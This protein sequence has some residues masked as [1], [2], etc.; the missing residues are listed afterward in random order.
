MSF[1]NY[2]INNFSLNQ[3]LSYQDL[4]DLAVNDTILYNK[5]QAMPRGI[6]GFAEMRQ[7]HSTIN[8]FKPKS[9]AAST[10]PEDEYD[11]FLLV[12]QP[13]PSAASPTPFSVT[14]SVEDMRLV[15]F[16]FYAADFA[17]TRSVATYNSSTNLPGQFR[18]AFFLKQNNNE[19]YMLN[20]TYKTSAIVKT[21][22]AAIMQGSLSMHYVTQVPAG[23]HTL[24][25]GFICTNSTIVIGRAAASRPTQL[26]VEDLGAYIGPGAEVESEF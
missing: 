21:T 9:K 19:A 6:I 26:Y 22:T 12:R 4:N 10:T 16:S 14:F 23:T 13:V 25:A 1:K 17:D 11:G 7:N 3:V 5:I 24:L 15:K 20:S 2:K 8:T 18:S